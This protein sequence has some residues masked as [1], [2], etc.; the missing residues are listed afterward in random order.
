MKKQIEKYCPYLFMRERGEKKCIEEHCAIWDERLKCCSKKNDTK[1]DEALQEIA[2]LLKKE[3]SNFLETQEKNKKQ[4][5]K[6]DKDI[7]KKINQGMNMK[8]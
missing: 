6:L 2:E 7:L 3:I 4:V 8:N 1:R 5:V